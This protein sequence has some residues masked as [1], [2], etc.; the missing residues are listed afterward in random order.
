MAGQEARGELVACAGGVDDL[1]DRLRRH[2][3]PLAVMD[4]DRALFALGRDQQRHLAG[5]G[6]DARLEVAF[7]RQ[8]CQFV[9][10]DEQDVD[11]TVVDHGA[12]IVAVAVDHE[13]FAGGEGNLAPGAAGH[14]DRAAHR[15]ARF[16]GVPQI[17]FEIEDRAAGDQVLVQRGCRQELARA[18][19]G[20]HRPL[21][22]GRHEDQAAPGRR[23]VAERRRVEIDACGAHVVGE[24]FAQLVVAHLADEGALQAEQ[25]CARQRVRRRSAGDFARL[26]HR[27]V[28]PRRALGIDQRHSAAI[29]A[30]L[31]N[32][33]VGAAGDDV[34]HGVADGDDVVTGFGHGI[35]CR[36]GRRNRPPKQIGGSGA[37]RDWR[38]DRRHRPAMQASLPPGRARGRRSMG[39]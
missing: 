29:E 32:E 6:G 7:A 26:A 31:G 4:G 19:E 34:D 24:D 5:D 21:A 13:A 37:R 8:R 39:N 27:V 33:F 16:L 2:F 25:R 35:S 14:V 9:F 12:E 18:E 10:V 22:I 28:Q 15:L 36:L 11:H 20:V 17:T 38:R 3:G 1:V 30:K 23:L